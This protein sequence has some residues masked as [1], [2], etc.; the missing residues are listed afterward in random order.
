ML[1]HLAV[2]GWQPA[3]AALLWAPAAA[4]TAGLLLTWWRQPRTPAGFA[5]G[6][7][8][9]FLLLFLFSKKAFCNYYFL[10]IALLMAGVAAASSE[11]PTE[12]EDGGA[13]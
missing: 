10:V 6:L 4:L 11:F 8:T 3:P 12:K 7:G 1:S 9:A 2:R 5:T 13:R